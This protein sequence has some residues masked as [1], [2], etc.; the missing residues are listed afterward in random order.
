MSVYLLLT[1]T[2]EAT[3]TSSAFR[4]A[5]N[6][7]APRKPGSPTTAGFPALLSQAHGSQE[8]QGRPPQA[9]TLAQGLLAPAAPQDGGAREPPISH[10]GHCTLPVPGVAE[11]AEKSPLASVP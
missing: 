3:P 10:C 7:S 5:G 9:R 8:G 6:G 11:S 2:T 1:R 4:L